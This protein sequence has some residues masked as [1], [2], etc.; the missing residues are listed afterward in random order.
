MGSAGE[1]LIRRDSTPVASWSE[2]ARRHGLYRRW[3][4]GYEVRGRCVGDARNEVSI[5]ENRPTH[6]PKDNQMSVAFARYA[7]CGT[8]RIR[9]ERDQHPNQKMDVVLDNPREPDPSPLSGHA[10]S[11]LAQAAHPPLVNDAVATPPL[12]NETGGTG[13][14]P[15]ERLTS[16][17]RIA[18]IIPQSDSRTI[19]KYSSRFTRDFV[20]SDYNF[21]AAKVTVARKGKLLALDAA[22]RTADEWLTKAVAWIEKRNARS[23]PLFQEEV[24]LII[25]HPLAGRLVRC[26]TQYDRLSTRSME[27]VF[28]QKLQPEERATLLA[29]AEK[30]I[31]HIVH[32][33]VPDNDQYDFAGSRREE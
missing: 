33:C 14:K 24:E 27:A 5:A 29:N 10:L 18:R 23:F 26:L 21:C 9:G 3:T 13:L 2:H 22:F 8:R 11:T 6:H 31:R 16:D 30:R 7:V 20:R 19:L 32:V 25:T 12:P 4:S 28:A 17:L 1:A 15:I